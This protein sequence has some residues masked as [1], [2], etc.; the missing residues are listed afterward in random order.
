MSMIKTS[1][2]TK[3]FGSFTA[4][5]EVDFEVNEGEIYGFYRAEWCW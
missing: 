2:L 4:L 3:R 5:Q 1:K